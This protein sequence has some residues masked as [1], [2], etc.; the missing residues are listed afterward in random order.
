VSLS[1][2]P[3]KFYWSKILLG[4]VEISL[5]NQLS[6]NILLLVPLRIPFFFHWYFVIFNLGER[7]GNLTGF[8][9]KYRKTSKVFPKSYC[10]ISFLMPQE[11]SLN[12]LESSKISWEKYSEI[13]EENQ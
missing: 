6:C 11:L 8:S 1:L 2:G 3:K 4:N 7:E 10:D 5:K 9:K 13:S 12:F